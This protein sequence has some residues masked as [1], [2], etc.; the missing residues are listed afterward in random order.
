MQFKVGDKVK[1]TE[2]FLLILPR[3]T[4]KVKNGGVIIKVFEDEAMV[5]FRSG[6]TPYIYLSS[7]ELKSVK[8]Q[9]L[10]FEFMEM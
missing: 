8:N 1:V 10:L 3:L 9:Q 7:L 5:K 6:Y 4:D 2:K